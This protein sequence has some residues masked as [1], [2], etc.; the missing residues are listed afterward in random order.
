ML[1]LNFGNCLL[2]I[3]TNCPVNKEN[4]FRNWFFGRLLLH[5]TMIYQHLWKCWRQDK[6]IISCTDSRILFTSFFVFSISFSFSF[7]SIFL[8]LRFSN[9]I[10]VHFSHCYRSDLNQKHW[11]I[12]FTTDFHDNCNKQNLFW[13]DELY[14]NKT[15][16]ICV[17]HKQVTQRPIG[18]DNQH[19]INWSIESVWV[20]VSH[21]LI[22]HWT[23]SLTL[24]RHNQNKL[25]LK[26]K[27]FL[28]W[29]SFLWN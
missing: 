14:W 26:K 4:S 2:Q 13:F 15:M 5:E 25:L 9:G 10:F 12:T 18:I 8:F 28:F 7:S 29:I 20:P 3:L 19:K 11:K 23:D 1:V 17:Q 27:V 22:E 16:F 21:I 24:D 6:I